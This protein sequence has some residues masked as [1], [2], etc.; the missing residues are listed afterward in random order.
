[1]IDFDRLLYGDGPPPPASGMMLFCGTEFMA[2]YNA[3][4]EFYGRDWRRI[5]RE[6]RKASDRARKENRGK[7][8]GIARDSASFW[9]NR[10]E[11]V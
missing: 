3:N 8:N 6:V 5:K 10:F 1:M 2:V 7:P 4:I 11:G 9:R